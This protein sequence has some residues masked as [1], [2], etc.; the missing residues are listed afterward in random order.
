MQ[1]TC[2]ARRLPDIIIEGDT[3]LCFDAIDDESN[4]PWSIGPLIGNIGERSKYFMSCSFCWVKKE[5][6]Y[7]AHAL[8][9]FASFL[10][11]ISFPFSCDKSF[12][13]QVVWDA[14]K[15]DVLSF[16]FDEFILFIKNDK[17]MAMTTR[18]IFNYKKIQ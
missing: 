14:C 7:V 5:I 8:A 18:K 12:I 2:T 4:T 6:I 11:S 9:K 10:N 13:P 15:V 17:F 1:R 16:S 3:K